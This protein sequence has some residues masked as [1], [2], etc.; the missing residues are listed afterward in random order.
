MNCNQDAILGFEAWTMLL[1]H[2]GMDRE[3]DE[4]FAFIEEWQCQV[5][6]KSAEWTEGSKPTIMSHG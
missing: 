4:I 1:L 6:T 5:E 3:T 2:I